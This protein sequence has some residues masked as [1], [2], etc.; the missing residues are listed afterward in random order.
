MPTTTHDKMRKNHL[1]FKAGRA[2]E[3]SQHYALFA[4][5]DSLFLG[6]RAAA[7]QAVAAARL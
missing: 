6:L 4:A 2:E 1:P 7:P 3:F 5:G